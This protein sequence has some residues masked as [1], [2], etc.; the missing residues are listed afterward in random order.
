MVCRGNPLWLPKVDEIILCTFLIGFAYVHL[1]MKTGDINL[2]GSFGETLD[3]QMD[4]S[5]DT[6]A[7]PSYAHK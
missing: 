4:L 1:F 5:M 7:V 2:Q 6:F 3:L